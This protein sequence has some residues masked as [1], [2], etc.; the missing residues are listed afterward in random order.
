MFEEQK[1]QFQSRLNETLGA[2]QKRAHAIEAEARKIVET[3]SDRAQAELK[4]LL[5][6][7]Q[8]L[9]KEQVSQ[10]GGELVKLG[11]R[12]Q[13]VAKSWKAASAKAEGAP[14]HTRKKRAAPSN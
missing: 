4:V 8:G 6:Q 11:T 12:L 2:A 1:S 14:A 9:S 3:L 10:L 13:E 5:V 7:A